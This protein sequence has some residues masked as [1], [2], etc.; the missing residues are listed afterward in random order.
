MASQDVLDG[1][2]RGQF[3]DLFGG[4][5]AA[6]ALFERMHKAGI[7]RPDEGGALATQ[8]LQARKVIVL[9]TN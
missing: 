2:E 1:L 9:L 3:R 5:H 6:E 8:E 4:E 7:E